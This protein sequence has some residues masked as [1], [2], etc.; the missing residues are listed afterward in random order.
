VIP[1]FYMVNVMGSRLKLPIWSK[2]QFLKEYTV[3]IPDIAQVHKTPIDIA[4]ISYLLISVEFVII[5]SI[6]AAVVFNLSIFFV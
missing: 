1:V 6:I 3:S 5:L 4:N 2:V